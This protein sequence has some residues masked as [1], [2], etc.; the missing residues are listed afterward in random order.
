MREARDLGLA[1]F[2]SA[3]GDEL[4]MEIQRGKVRITKTVAVVERNNDPGRLEDLADYDTALVR[5]L[6]ILAL[7][8]DDKVTP[9]LPPLRRL[10]GAVVA[11]VPEE[12]VGL[13][14]G[15]VTADVIY[16]LNNQR[17]GSVGDLRA[18]LKG[19]KTG[20]PLVFHVERS[21]QLIYVTATL[22]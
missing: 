16:S 12:Y 7:N 22:E 11:A 9:I 2:K 20:D 19:K 14:P 13:N 15:L 3:P 5:R 21:G 1:V 18:A 6:G 10:Y 17:I 8:L 4:T